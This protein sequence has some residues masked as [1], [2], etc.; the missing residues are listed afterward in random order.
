M[1]LSSP[2]DSGENPAV[3]PA[4][5]VAMATYQGERYLRAQ[6]DSIAAQTLQPLELVI[7]DDGSVDRTLEIAQDFAKTV[8]FP[9]RVSPNETRLRYA[10]N[11]LRAAS[12]CEGDLIACCDQDD[13]WKPEKLRTCA[14]PFSNPS[15]LLVLH[16]AQTFSDSNPL[17]HHFPAVPEKRILVSGE[18]DPFA[19]RPGFAMVVRRSLVTLATQ[20]TRPPS[21]YSHDHWFW[22]LASSAGSIAT[23]PE[24]LTLYRQHEA[25]VYGAGDKKT[26][27][28]QLKSGVEIPGYL[29][30]AQ[31]EQR[32][33]EALQ[34]ALPHSPL[35]WIPA[36]QHSIENLLLRA[37]FHRLRGA[38]Y[39]PDSTLF[40]RIGS[41]ATLLG[42]GAYRADPS[43]TRMGPKS[44]AK[45]A[46]LGVMGLFRRRA[47]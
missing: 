26:L 23:L 47:S 16:A 40:H 24:V 46:V 10:D 20:V 25:N 44:A 13:L 22:F 15:V 17:G 36:I 21:L 11:F 35:E 37:R 32:C 12:L 33:V 9:V 30:V 41:F 1:I 19:N 7:T 28:G 14:E 34:N 29:D 27:T 4:I 45:D 38:L 31:A 5:S 3:A 39:A 18:S 2:S 43:R 6:L 42:N 8:P